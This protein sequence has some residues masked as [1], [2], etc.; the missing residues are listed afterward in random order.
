[1]SRMERRRMMRSKRMMRSNRAMRS[2]NRSR[3]SQAGNARDPNR[4]VRAQSQGM[5]T[6]GPRY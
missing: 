2:M 5:T 6:G 3:P 4:P 1:M